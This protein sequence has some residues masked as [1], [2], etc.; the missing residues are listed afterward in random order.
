MKLSLGSK[1]VD[2]QLAGSGSLPSGVQ[3]YQPGSAPANEVDTFITTQGEEVGPFVA[4]QANEVDTFLTKPSYAAAD[5]MLS[6][7][8]QLTTRPDGIPPS[9]SHSLVAS[10][11]QPHQGSHEFGWVGEML[12][13]AAAA[14]ADMLPPTNCAC[15]CICVGSPLAL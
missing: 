8:P 13:A 11:L 12:Q 2:P 10:Q 15:P 6:S 14:C 7:D 5:S 1:E 3:H 9:D 4:T